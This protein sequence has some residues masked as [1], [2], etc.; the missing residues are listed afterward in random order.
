MVHLAVETARAAGLRAVEAT[1][2]PTRKNRPCLDFWSRTGFEPVG[3]D[4]YRWDAAVPYPAPRGVEIV[5]RG[6]AS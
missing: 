1:A 4:T 2:I 3:A 5:G 6:A